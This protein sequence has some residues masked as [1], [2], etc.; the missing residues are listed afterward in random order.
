MEKKLGEEP[1]GFQESIL[2][3]KSSLEIKVSVIFPKSILESLEM[4]VEDLKEQSFLLLERTI[5]KHLSTSMTEFFK[6]HG[7][8]TTNTFDYVAWDSQESPFGT[9][10]AHMT[11]IASRT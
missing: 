8:K 2:V 6:E 9:I 1:L 5:D 7:M 10:S 3:P 4:T 11:S